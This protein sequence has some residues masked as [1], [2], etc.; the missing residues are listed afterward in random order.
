M[1]EH[2]IYVEKDAEKAAELYKLAAD[3]GFELAL[4]KVSEL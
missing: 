4:E 3:Q 1:Y 2:G